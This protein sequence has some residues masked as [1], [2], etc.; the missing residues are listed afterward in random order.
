VKEMRS[1]SKILLVVLA[2]GIALPAAAS[3]PPARRLMKPALLVIDVQKEFLP[4]MSEQDRKMAPLTINGAI[5]LFRMHGFPVIRI[6]HTDPQWGPKEDSEGFKFD[7]A[8]QV[9]PEDPMIVKNSPSGFKKTDLEKLLREKGCNTLFLCGLSATG[10]VLATYHGATVL[11]FD[12]FM[13]KGGLI[14]PNSAHTEVIE[15][16]SETVTFEGM[17]V[18][19]DNAVQE[20]AER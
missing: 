14:S 19:L 4:F 12:A 1:V 15:D 7:D 10:C 16:I 8:I 6:Y 2:I 11:D 13:I 5:W 17:R 3:D 18:M 9:K 20:K